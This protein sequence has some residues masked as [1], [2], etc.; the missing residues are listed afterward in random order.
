M[1]RLEQGPTCVFEG[2]EAA[3]R[4]GGEAARRRGGED[5]VTLSHW[6]GHESPN[7]TFEHYAHFMPQSGAKGL[8]AVDAP[9]RKVFDP[10]LRGPDLIHGP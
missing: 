4:R 6:L 2:G 8:T 7:I 1:A 10:Q 5:I 3:R 9:A